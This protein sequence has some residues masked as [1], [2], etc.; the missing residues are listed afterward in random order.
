MHL[1][2]AED[3]MA[4]FTKDEGVGFQVLSL[5]LLTVLAVALAVTAYSHKPVPPAEQPTH[6]FE[7]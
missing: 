3:H 5:V 4:A 7:R 6:F 1:L 2:E